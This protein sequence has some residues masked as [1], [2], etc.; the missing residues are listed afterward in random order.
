MNRR[1]I[2]KVEILKTLI[3]QN[4]RFSIVQ[5]NNDT[6]LRTSARLVHIS[7]NRTA[8]TVHDIVLIIIFKLNHT[9]TDPANNAACKLIGN[10]E[11]VCFTRHKQPM[12]R[13]R[14]LLRK[15]RLRIHRIAQRLQLQIQCLHT[16]IIFFHRRQNTDISRLI[17]LVQPGLIHIQNL[18]H[19]IVGLI[20]KSIKLKRRRRQIQ[21]PKRL[22]GKNLPIVI[23]HR[24]C[25]LR[26]IVAGQSLIRNHSRR[27]LCRTG[28]GYFNQI[29]KHTSRRN[30][31]ELVN[32]TDQN[33]LILLCLLKDP[34]HIIQANHGCLVQQNQACIKFR[35]ARK[36]TGHR[37]GR[38]IGIRTKHLCMVR[39]RTCRIN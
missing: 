17:M 10:L 27:T 5:L 2:T 23:R 12:T 7:D 32:I 30:R 14:F 6:T 26:T 19:T 15:R 34:V 9:V 3:R 11:P 1:R 36:I 16:G 21:I 18:L 33:N 20:I 24:P 39:H 37:P 28:T 8:I 13:R 25:A 22:T 31:R 29:M 35:T 38:P 4:P